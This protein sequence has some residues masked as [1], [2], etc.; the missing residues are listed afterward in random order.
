MHEIVAKDLDHEIS[1]SCSE[2]A[3]LHCRQR[4]AGSK[5]NKPQPEHKPL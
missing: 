2:L 4:Y 3:S 5:E 1:G